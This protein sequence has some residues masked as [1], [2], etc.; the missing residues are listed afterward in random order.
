M[1]RGLLLILL[2][3][4][5]VG[6]SHTEAAPASPL[7][8]GE[9]WLS[10]ADVARN[11]VEEDTVQLRGLDD[12]LVSSG[13]LSFDEGRVAHVISPVT[14]RVE[15]IE[16]SLGQ[17]VTKGQTLAVLRSPDLGDAT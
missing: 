7:P 5:A 1:T 2:A 13:R 15:R 16:G 9:V 6:C 4:A 14:G 8:P 17:H 12:I 3:V 11:H 10:A